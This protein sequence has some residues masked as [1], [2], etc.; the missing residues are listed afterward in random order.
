MPSRKPISILK[1]KVANEYVGN[2]TQTVWFD[3]FLNKPDNFEAP[4]YFPG[5]HTNIIKCSDR[6]KATISGNTWPPHRLLR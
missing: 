3:K 5:N 6:T 2:Y 1:N 4:K